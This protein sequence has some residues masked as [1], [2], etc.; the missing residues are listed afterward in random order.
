MS[1][2]L[3]SWLSMSRV[4]LSIMVRKD[5]N[6]SDSLELWRRRRYTYRRQVNFLLYTLNYSTENESFTQP[7]FDLSPTSQVFYSCSLTWRNQM[8]IFGGEDLKR[9][10]SQVQKCSLARI[11]NVE[12]FHFAESFEHLFDAN[13]RN[14]GF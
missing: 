12:N 11:G 6:F 8:L 3:S 5:I 2:W 9:Q 7:N 14:T 10:I 13:T 4:R 1:G